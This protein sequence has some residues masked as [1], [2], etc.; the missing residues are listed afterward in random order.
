MYHPVRPRAVYVV[1]QCQR[2]TVASLVMVRGGFW[3]LKDRHQAVCVGQDPGTVEVAGERQTSRHNFVW[4]WKYM[5]Q[6]RVE[7]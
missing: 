2:E 5:V 4:V 7:A 3:R 6:L 1:L